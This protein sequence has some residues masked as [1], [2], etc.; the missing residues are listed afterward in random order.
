[1]NNFETIIG[2]EIH[3]ELNTKSK[4]FSSSLN[5]LNSEPNTN[6][7]PVDVGYPGALPIVNKEAVIRSIKLAKALKMKI[8]KILYFDRKHYMYP[9]L[10]KGYQITQQKRPIGKE[11]IITL[12]NGH[13]VS[14]ERIHMEEDTARSHHDP[15]GTL[16]DFNRAGVPLIEIVTDP[17]IRSPE[18]ASQYISSIRQLAKTLGISDAKMEEGSLRADIN[19]SLRPYGQ[20]EFGTKVEIKNINSISNVRKAIKLEILEQTKKLVTGQLVQ[21]STKRFDDN[22]N[23][24][25]IMRIKS[26][27]SDYRY[28]PEP[29]IPPI[30]LADDFIDSIALPELPWEIES[31]LKSE[32]VEQEFINQLISDSDKLKLFDKI[33]YKNKNRLSKLFFA[34]IVKT[35]NERK[36]KVSQLNILPEEIKVTLEKQDAGEISGAHVKKIIPL[37]MEGKKAQDIIDKNNFKQ[38]SNKTEILKI[39]DNV[40]E[41]NTNFIEKNKDRPERILKFINGQVMKETKGQVN[42]I[43]STEVIKNKLGL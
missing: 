26:D 34:E 27:A 14:I 36:I 37:L 17:V 38:I 31:R 43:V 42:P 35:A 32:K 29:N 6:L 13:K 18:D 21:Q 20:E 23:T 40:F 8:D 25:V 33:E 16:L 15:E 28:F 30:K 5:D 9:D 19:I 3:L 22:S 11:G 4:M 7:S 2:I 12:E 10:P 24:N 41:K 39:V 1:M